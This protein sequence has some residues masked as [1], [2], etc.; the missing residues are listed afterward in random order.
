MLILNVGIVII[1]SI[2]IIFKFSF[3]MFCVLSG[4]GLVVVY[5]AAGMWNVV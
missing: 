3:V 5:L 1:C 2:M 4:C